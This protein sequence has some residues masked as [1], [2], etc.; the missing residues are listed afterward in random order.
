MHHFWHVQCTAD[1]ATI[2]NNTNSV[3]GKKI[4]EK[5]FQWYVFIWQH[6][7]NDSVN[8]LIRMAWCQIY[9]DY[10]LF[11]DAF[12]GYHAAKGAKVTK[13]NSSY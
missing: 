11:I 1:L 4:L 7:S 12:I 10:K 2:W 6:I 8:S 9:N 5:S 3:F 13:M